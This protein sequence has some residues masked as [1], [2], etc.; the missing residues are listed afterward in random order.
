MG[1]LPLALHSL[2]DTTTRL[3]FRARHIWS[4]NFSPLATLGA[5]H[6]CVHTTLKPARSAITY[7][8][9]ATSALAYIWTYVAQ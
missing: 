4:R 6:T 1:E 5:V 2:A 7:N 3:V 9:T 8:G